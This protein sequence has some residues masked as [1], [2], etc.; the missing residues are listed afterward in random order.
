MD[1]A[2]TYLAENAEWI[3]GGIGVTFVS[4]VGVI[5]FRLLS[6]GRS[7]G[8]QQQ[9]QIGGSHSVNVQIGTINKDDA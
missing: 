3:F 7:E 9:S 5:L 2:L 6:R 8:G 1:Q 4:G